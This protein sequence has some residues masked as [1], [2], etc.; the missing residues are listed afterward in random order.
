MILITGGLGYIGSHTTIELLASGYEVIVVDDLSNSSIECLKRIEYISGKKITFYQTD[1]SDEV[2]MRA[3]FKK[4]SVDKVIHF[5]GKKAVG[6]SIKYPLLYYRNNIGGFAILIKVMQ[7][8][9]CKN[10]VFSSSAAVYGNPTQNPIKESSSVSPTNPYSHSKFVIEEILRYLYSSDNT[11]QIVILRYFN[12]I[13]AHKSG[14]IGDNP[15]GIPNNIMPYISQIAVGALEKLKVF[16]DDYATDDGTGVRDYIHVI[17]L[18]RGHIK[19]IEANGLNEILTINLGTGKGYSVLD[20]ISAFE[21]CSGKKIPYEVVERRDGD[22]D[23]CYA[24]I[25]YAKEILGWTAEYTLIEMC[26]D[27]WRWQSKNP[28]GMK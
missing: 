17:D 14:L 5:A 3:I 23:S 7:E 24:D 1:I 18:A 22:V 16:G 10:I 20:L 25:S 2:S 13:G 8:F 21:S 28:E 9:G 26:E 4:H 19:A 11:W 6:E 12:P 27:T 15:K